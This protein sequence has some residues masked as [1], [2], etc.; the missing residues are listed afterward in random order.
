MTAETITY[1]D[2]D[3]KVLK[4]TL[5]YPWSAQTASRARENEDG[6]AADPLLAHRTGVRRTDE[7]QTQDSGWRAVRTLTTVDDT[8]GLPTQ[9]ETAV[10]KPDGTAE[11]L[12]DQTC[13]K[14]SYLH[15]TT[16]W[17]IGLPKEQRSTGTSCAAHDSADP[18]TKLR[19]AARFTYDGLSYGATP[20]RGMVTS[21]AEI[22]GA[23]TAYSFVVTT[24]YDPLGR[25]R[26]VTSPGQGT[27]ETRYTPAD[28]GGP[29][30]EVKSLDAKGYETITAYDPGRG[31]PL[32]VTD[33]NGRVTRT[34]YDALGRLVKGWSSSRSGAG[35]SPSVQ[36]AYQAAIATSAENRPAAVTVK[37][38]KDDGSYATG[39]TL[40]DGLGREVQQQAEAHGPGR[41]IVDTKYDDHGLVHEKTGAIWRR[42]NR[43]RLCS[44]R[45]RSGCSPHG[46]STATTAWNARS[47]R[48]PTRA[49]TTRTRPTR[50]TA[51]PARSWT[52][53]ARPGRKPGRPT[54]PSAGSPC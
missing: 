34:E 36:I 54:T 25:V 32:S 47:G 7:I 45:S 24:T 52:L 2:S 27:T 26:T 50:P 12:S 40:Y 14:T 22:D 38:L 30:T 5:D 29:V 21:K 20:T 35:Q 3:G 48:L 49:T 17:L 46:P 33:P 39:I 13:T 44:P 43:T 4:R 37:T 15:N 23:G 19:S 18:A 11:T 16:A 8:Y 1:R 6:T 9:V 51:C 31:L 41:I 28:E 53:R 42:E 10:V